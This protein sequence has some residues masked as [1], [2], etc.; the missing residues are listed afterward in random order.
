MCIYVAELR[1]YFGLHLL[2]VLFVQAA[3]FAIAHHE[4]HLGRA[5]AVSLNMAVNPASIVH[6]L[7]K[8]LVLLEIAS[9]VGVEFAEDVQLLVEQVGLTALASPSLL[10]EFRRVVATVNFD[11]FA[12]RGSKAFAL[13]HVEI[14]FSDNQM[15]EGAGLLQRYRTHPQ[16]AEVVLRA[17]SFHSWGELVHAKVL[18]GQEKVQG[19]ERT[20]LDSLSDGDSEQSVVTL[21]FHEL[22]AECP[23]TLGMDDSLRSHDGVEIRM[24][25]GCVD[26][27]SLESVQ[28]SSE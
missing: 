5:L 10:G 28:L 3:I 19:L 4:V 27:L 8:A 14:V 16:V 12:D 25:F 23:D 22:L 7:G 2:L 6:Q 15:Q 9:A 24:R 26:V 1:R 11:L 20:R 18:H 17:A 13:V 21:A